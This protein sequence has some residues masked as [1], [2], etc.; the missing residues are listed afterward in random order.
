MTSKSKTSKTVMTTTE[1]ATNLGTAREALEL[2]CKAFSK[3]AEVKATMEEKKVGAYTSTVAAAIAAGSL[4][5]FTDVYAG[6]V[7]D[8]SGNVAGIARQL[9]CKHGKPDKSGKS[10]YV[11]PGSL[12]VA[13]SVIKSAMGHKIPLQDKDGQRSYGSIRKDKDAADAASKEATETPLQTAQRRVREAA[14]KIAEGSDALTLTEANDCYK[15]LQNLIAVESG[16]H[17]GTHKPLADA[18]ATMSAAA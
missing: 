15:I 3:V 5:A 12:M 14:A 1:L 6:L 13:V 2:S 18:A 8:I 17:K 11:V 9:G 4:T 10:V 16:S 7:A